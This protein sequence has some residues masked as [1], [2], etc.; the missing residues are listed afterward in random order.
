M[1]SPE[2]DKR[3][4][5]TQ[6]PS[7]AFGRTKAD[8]NIT[9]NVVS[10]AQLAKQVSDTRTA[11]APASESFTNFDRSVEDAMWLLIYAA[12]TGRNVDDATRNSILRAKAVGSAGWDETIAANLLAA[13][14][15]LAAQLNPVTADSLRA[16]TDETKPT[17]NSLRKWTFILAVPIILVSLLSFVSSSISSAIRTDISTANELAVKLRAELGTSMAAK[18]G[19]SDSPA[20]PKVLE[21]DVITQL[22]L[23]AST[24]RAIEARTRQLN[25]FVLHIERDPFAKYQWSKTLSDA[26]NETNQ[27]DLKK[28]FQ[29]PVGL[30]DMPRL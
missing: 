26:D 1:A 16:S 17:I 22:Q 6:S 25:W 21:G 20:L 8:L 30:P 13:L 18:G 4:D 29:L 10:S 3:L 5:R 24:I 7:A 9:D 19:T 23:Y 12:D 27:K 15:K 2:L 11:P 14:T 28:K